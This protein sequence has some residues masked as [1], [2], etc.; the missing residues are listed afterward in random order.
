MFDV[1]CFRF[2]RQPI[3]HTRTGVQMLRGRA[4]FFTQPPHVRVHWCGYQSAVVF[5]RPSR[6]RW[7]R[8]CTRPARWARR[9]WELEFRRGQFNR[10]VFPSSPRCRGSSSSRSPKRNWSWGFSST[11]PR[12][13]IFFDAE[14]QLARAERL[15][16]SNPPAR[17]RGRARVNLRSLG[18]E[19]ED[20]HAR[21]GRI[22]PERLA[23]LEASSP[24][25]H[26]EHDEIGR[27]RP[28]FFKAS[29]PS[30]AVVTA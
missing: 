11:W 2:T 15:G 1:R 20:R 25:H 7:S 19:H 26:V 4:E 3:A 28:R 14:Q 22:E 27:L 6:N 13:R 16:Q 17:V 21:G 30:A 18:R 12:A 23:D 9:G 29:A 8:D 5:P 24:Q 10:L